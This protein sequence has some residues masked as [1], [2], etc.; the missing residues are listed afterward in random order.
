MYI[1]NE[2]LHIQLLVYQNQSTQSNVIITINPH[3]LMS[4]SQS[5]HFVVQKLLCLFGTI[6][7]HYLSTERILLPMVN[8]LYNVTLFISIHKEHIFSIYSAYYILHHCLSY[9]SIDAIK[10]SVN[11]YCKL[12]NISIYHE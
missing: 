2:L 11:K 10:I 3:S 12:C 6:Y 7:L 9:A 5:I 1:A 4:L 8:G